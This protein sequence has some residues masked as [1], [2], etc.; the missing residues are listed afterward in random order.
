[1]QE[2]VPSPENGILTFDNLTVD[3]DSL[4]AFAINEGAF[5]FTDNNQP[6]KKEAG[7]NVHSK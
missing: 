4:E 6:R 7:R 2:P 1:M 5:G 3:F